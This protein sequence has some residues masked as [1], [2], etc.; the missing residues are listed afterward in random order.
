MPVFSWLEFKKSVAEY[1]GLTECLLLLGF[2]VPNPPSGD[3]IPCESSNFQCFRSACILHLSYQ[4]PSFPQD[5][6]ADP[7]CLHD[8]TKIVEGWIFI[9]CTLLDIHEI[10]DKLDFHIF[11][12]DR[13]SI[14]LYVYPCV[15]CIDY[16]LFNSLT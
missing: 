9:Y 3:G 14:L 2:V 12:Q 15:N 1:T 13:D 10:L 6:D 8:S 7:S 4:D 11:L 5:G 16:F